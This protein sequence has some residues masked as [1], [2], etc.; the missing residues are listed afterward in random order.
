MS[1]FLDPT[2]Q[3]WDLKAKGSACGQKK[4]GEI[5]ITLNEDSDPKLTIVKVTHLQGASCLCSQNESLG[6][7]PFLE[8]I[9]RLTLRK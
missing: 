2:L 5:V 9:F 6:V 8:Q 4:Q 3:N 7:W 1:S